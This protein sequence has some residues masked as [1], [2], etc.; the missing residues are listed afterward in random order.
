MVEGS[1]YM[2]NYHGDTEQGI[3]FQTLLSDHDN[4]IMRLVW[5]SSTKCEKERLKWEKQIFRQYPTVNTINH[6]D[7]DRALLGTIT[8]SEEE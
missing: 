5:V 3:L 6:I 8:R 1:E 2:S 4:S 7:E